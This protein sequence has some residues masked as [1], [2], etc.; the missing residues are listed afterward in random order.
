MIMQIRARLTIRQVRARALNLSL[1]QPVETASGVMQTT[2]LVLID[3]MTEEGITGRSYV[4]CY[5]LLAL[6]PLTT[7]VSNLGELLKGSSAAPATV[8]QKLLQQFRLIGPQGLTGMAMAGIDMALWDAHA[9]ACGMPL[10]TLLGGEP[11]PIP[12]YASLRS[13]S[14]E[15]AA[16]EA[17]QAL[18]LGFSAMK[19]KVGRGNLALD[20]E[21]IRAVRCAVGDA[22]KLMVDYNQSLSVVE[23]IDRGRVL[24]RENLYWI[25][26]PTRADDFE[27]HARIAAATETAIQLGENFWSPYDMVKSIA[28][29]ASDHLMLDVMKLGGVSGWLRASALA[30][31]S[32]LLAS[33]HTFPEFSAHLLGVTPTAHLLEYLDHTSPILIE[34]VQIQDGHVLIPDR[35]GSGI[36]WNEG[37]IRRLGEHLS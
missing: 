29:K 3:I 15:A 19:V 11:R 4:R 9:V 23:A 33:S 26:E 31:V 32:G 36:E 34:P 2:P 5:T 21:T 14:A 28:A 35:P 7:L 1:L 37:V 30:H 10:V 16:R 20:L 24:D 22:V 13:M 25:E 18:A 12:A 8:E 27:G 6:H 17:E